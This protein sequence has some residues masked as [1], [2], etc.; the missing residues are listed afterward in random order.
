MNSI[1]AKEEEVGKYL[2]ASVFVF[3]EPL[4]LGYLSL[5]SVVI[6]RLGNL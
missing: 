5:L 6:T 4:L 1:P 2:W 3:N